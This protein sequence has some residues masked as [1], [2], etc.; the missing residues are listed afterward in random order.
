MVLEKAA[1]NIVQ[2]CCT[3]GKQFSRLECKMERQDR[4]YCKIKILFM[5]QRK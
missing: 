4:F 3:L 5:R 1:R 2:T